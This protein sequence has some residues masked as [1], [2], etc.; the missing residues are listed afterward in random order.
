MFEPAFP[1]D[2]DWTASWGQLGGDPT[3]LVWLQAADAAGNTG[4]VV[5]VIAP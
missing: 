5:G 4:D 3:L 2:G 1:A